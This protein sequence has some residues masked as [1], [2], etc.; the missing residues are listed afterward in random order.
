MSGLFCSK[1]WRKGIGLCCRGN[2]VNL[3]HKS[4]R[5]FLLF[6]NV[7]HFFQ[8]FVVHYLFL[9]IQ[10]S[11][12]TGGGG[13][14]VNGIPNLRKGGGQEVK[15]APLLSE[16]D[17]RKYAKT[18]ILCSLKGGARGKWYVPPCPPIVRPLIQA[19]FLYVVSVFLLPFVT[20]HFILS[21]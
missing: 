6:P 20:L 2:V 10:I 5:V 9:S 18:L 12:I 13:G 15:M 4:R 14:K 8:C 3:S 11:G 16:T 17:C 19:F 7:M 21:H 1:F